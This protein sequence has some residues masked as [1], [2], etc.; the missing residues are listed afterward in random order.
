MQ[1]NIKFKKIEFEKDIEEHIQRK[2]ALALSRTAPYITAVSIT[3]SKTV[4]VKN[5]PD[6]H[7]LLKLSVID[8]PDVVIEDTQN[9]LYYVIDRAI[10]K[11]HRAMERVVTQQ[12]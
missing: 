8:S 7:C 4:D 5:K 1:V 6:K 3:L 10:Q 11:A 12:L 2:L 9:D